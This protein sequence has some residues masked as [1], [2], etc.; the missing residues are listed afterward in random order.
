MRVLSVNKFYHING[1]SERYMFSLNRLLEK[2]GHEIVPFSM[3]D[4]ANEPSL[5]ES[6]FVS[7]IDF[8]DSSSLS[9]KIRAAMRVI[10]SY[11]AS[12][13]I[14][15]LIAKVRPQIAHL[16]NIAHQL[17][18]SILYPLARSGIPVVQ[19]LH[20]YKLICPTYT[21]FTNNEVCERCLKGDFHNAALH[22]CNHDSLAA[23]LVNVVE[24]YVHKMMRSYDKIDLFISPS[25]F[26]RNKMIEAGVAPERVEHIPNFIDLER[27]IPRYDHDGYLLFFG[28]LT[29]VKGLDI[30]LEAMRHLPD[31]K[32]IVAGRGEQQKKFMTIV[33][34]HNL[35]VS[36][37]G[38]QSGQKLQELI[39][40]SMAVIVPSRWYENQP[41][42]VV[43]AFAYGKPVIGTQLGG[44][45][46]LIDD[47]VNGLLFKPDDPADLA[48][49]LRRVLENP[50][51]LSQ[52]GHAARMK[53][54]RCFNPGNHYDRIVEIYNR[55]ITSCS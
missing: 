15:S 5:F 4:R 40:G 42:A 28:Q 21:M 35:N 37:V 9:A 14:E 27:H 12:R 47:G 51:D 52:M 33:S 26:L 31:V 6:C 2:Y 18:P 19:T 46:E 36:F 23:S 11:E 22:R 48:D 53:A 8:F 41:Y 20:D 32:L 38:F 34:R 10:Y 7:G 24:M 55:F 13:K 45:A 29:S 43:E 17:S 25:R 30:L 54:E 49:K 1:G 44:I 50:G 3:S 39:R 16:H